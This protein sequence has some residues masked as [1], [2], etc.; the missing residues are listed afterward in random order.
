MSTF[1]PFF[2]TAHARDRVSPSQEDG[3]KVNYIT[4]GSGMACCY[5][6]GNL[7]RVPAGSVKFAMVRRRHHRPWLPMAAS[8][9]RDNNA[10]DLVMPGRRDDLVMPGRPPAD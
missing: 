1:D 6:D 3:S 8:D 10:E 9:A 2:W 4:T 7:N 5:P